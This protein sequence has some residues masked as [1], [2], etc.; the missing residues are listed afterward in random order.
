MGG[1][2][3][4]IETGEFPRDSGFSVLISWTVC[5]IYWHLAKHTFYEAEMLELLWHSIG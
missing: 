5:L 4:F 1:Q 3:V 2:A